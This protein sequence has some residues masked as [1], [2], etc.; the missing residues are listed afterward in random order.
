MKLYGKDGQFERFV[1]RRKD[2]KV[3]ERIEGGTWKKGGYRVSRPLDMG[4]TFS[5][6]K[7]PQ[8]KEGSEA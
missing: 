2:F 4:M 3:E 8:S 6:S 1:M 7:K 5:G